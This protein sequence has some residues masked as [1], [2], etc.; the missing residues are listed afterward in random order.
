MDLPATPQGPWSRDLLDGCAPL[1]YSAHADRHG[2]QAG[3]L[4]ARIRNVRTQN[5]FIV[6]ATRRE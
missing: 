2:G 5:L 1:T 3:E 4:N 6:A